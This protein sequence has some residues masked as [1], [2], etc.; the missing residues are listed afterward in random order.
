MQQADAALIAAQ[1]KS[2][3]SE[4]EL[5]RQSTLRS[6]DIS[7]QV[8]LD[9]A[10][11]QRDSDKA[12]VMSKEAGITLAK[13]NL[14]YTTV[15]A[16]FD[17]VVTKHLVSVGEL[18]GGSVTTKLASIVQLDPIYVSFNLSEQ[19][20]LRIRTNIGSEKV[21]LADKCRSRSVS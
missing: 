19:D 16:P 4:A 5:A 6:Q 21:M 20:L 2:V 12:N 7:T 1:A 13:I 11:A 17:G 15:T 3:R 9:Q 10:R 14:G 18:V 8:A